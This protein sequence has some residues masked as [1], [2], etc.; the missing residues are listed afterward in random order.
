MKRV[1]YCAAEHQLPHITHSDT[2]SPANHLVIGLK[3]TSALAGNKAEIAL[4]VPAEI[5]F[6]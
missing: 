3:H 5:L 1:G 4:L 6:C 2:G